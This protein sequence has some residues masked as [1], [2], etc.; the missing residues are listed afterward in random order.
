MPIGSF[1][2]HSVWIW[3]IGK[4]QLHYWLQC[5]YRYFQNVTDHIFCLRLKASALFAFVWA[6]N[7]PSELNH[8][9]MLHC[10]LEWISHPSAT[11][12]EVDAWQST[13]S[14]LWR[15][16]GNQGDMKLS[17]TSSYLSLDTYFQSQKTKSEQFGRKSCV[18]IA[19]APVTL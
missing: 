17:Q 4:A 16:L 1:S 6:V 5:P 13:A 2:F 12:R 15:W 11:G 9:K 14:K 18:M 7:E 19:H 10:S 3:A 8:D